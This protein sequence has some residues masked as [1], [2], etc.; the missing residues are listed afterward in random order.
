MKVRKSMKLIKFILIII[1]SFL[2]ISCSKSLDPVPNLD[3]EFQILDLDGNLKTSFN[4]NDTMIFKYKISNYTGSDLTIHTYQSC[5][6]VQFLIQRDT[7]VIK[8]SFFG[9]GFPQVAYSYPFPKNET[10]GY[11]WKIG[12]SGFLP[13]KYII[14]AIS[15]FNI[16]DV[17]IPPT[18]TKSVTIN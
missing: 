11:N 13:G 14:N 16:E 15:H 18:M 12:T 17:G 5:P 2:Y 9:L 4:S 8:D 6:I 10:I 1:I 7:L 3:K